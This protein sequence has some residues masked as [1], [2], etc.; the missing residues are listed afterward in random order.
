MLL[1]E[2]G[3]GTPRILRLEGSSLILLDATRLDQS[4]ESQGRP[5]QGQKGRKDIITLGPLCA[6]S[7]NE[8]L[9]A[10]LWD[11]VRHQENR[12][13]PNLEALCAA[14]VEGRILQASR[15]LAGR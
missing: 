1:W 12:K 14:S 7:L 3:G 2:L 11:C 4:G 9:T 13:F 15:G 5:W 8:V 10:H 6:A